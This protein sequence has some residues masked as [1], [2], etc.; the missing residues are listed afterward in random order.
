MGPNIE[1]LEWGM[2]MDFGELVGK[3]R[4]KQQDLADSVAK[5]QAEY[6]EA[7]KRWSAGVQDFIALSLPTIPFG[8][9]E[10]ANRDAGFFGRKNK[11]HP[12]GTG[13][14]LQ[15]L[16]HGDRERDGDNPIFLSSTGDLYG[17]RERLDD[18]ATNIKSL[19]LNG[20]CPKNL[21]TGPHC[22]L[23]RNSHEKPEPELPLF[24]DRTLELLAKYAVQHLKGKTSK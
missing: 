14:L 12:L 6:Q 1:A 23:Q 2:D 17:V 7:L 18:C 11:F 21:P 19:T 16:T 20:G 4:Q 9:I 13:W 24:P 22:A 3:E 8:W 15:A 5:H 10:R